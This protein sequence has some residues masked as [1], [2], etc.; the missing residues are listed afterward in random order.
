MRRWFIMAVL[1]SALAAVP[2]LAQECPEG[3]DCRTGQTGSGGRSPILGSGVRTT[4]EPIEEECPPGETCKQQGSGGR[5]QLGS[6]GRTTESLA[7]EECTDEACRTGQGGSGGRG[8]VIGSGGR[9]TESQ[10]E[11]TDETT[12][13][14]GQTGS[15]GRVGGGGLGS[16]NSVAGIRWL[17]GRAHDGSWMLFADITYADG[18]TEVI[19]IN[20]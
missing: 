15:G 7:E 5:S 3:E 20:R 11:C 4:S 13:R 2:L 17:Q 9:T 6:G 16:G 1:F 14:T 8:P 12:C 19:A 18:S 10:D